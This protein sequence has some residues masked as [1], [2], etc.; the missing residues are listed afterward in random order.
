[1]I[2]SQIQDKKQILNVFIDFL[3]I[4]LYTSIKETFLSFVLVQEMLTSRSNKTGKHDSC[5]TAV[6]THEMGIK[7]KSI[8]HCP[9]LK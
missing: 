4:N 9:Q 5:I 8:R 7:N 2:N 6:Y 3:C 1:M